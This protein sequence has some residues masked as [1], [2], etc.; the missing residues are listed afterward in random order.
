MT[1]KEGVSGYLSYVWED[2]G[3]GNM[4][5]HESISYSIRFTLRNGDLIE[6]CSQITPLRPDLEAG[7]EIGDGHL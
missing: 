5:D 3:C 1:H 4:N 7:G 2:P 6:L